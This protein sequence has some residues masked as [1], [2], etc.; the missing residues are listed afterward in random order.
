MENK[1]KD[2]RIKR[3]MLIILCSIKVLYIYLNV[4][5]LPEYWSL[6]P[7]DRNINLSFVIIEF[8]FF[9][10]GLRIFLSFY[11][12]GNPISFLSTILICLYFIPN[13]SCMTLSGYDFVYYLLV[14]SFCFILFF[15]LGLLSKHIEKKKY[16]SNSLFENSATLRNTFR[17]ITILTCFLTIGYVYLI[18]G[19]INISKIVQ[20]DTYDVRAQ[21]ADFYMKNTD[22]L[23]AY[24]MLIWTAFYTIV[25]ILGLYL[26]LVYKHY[27]DVIFI[28]F[29]YLALYTLSMEKSLLMKPII[30]IFVSIIA[31]KR[32]LIYS[33]ETFTL[34]YVGL[35]IISWVEYLFREE[36]VIYTVLI[37]RVAYMPAYLTHVFYDFFDTHEKYWFTR[38][39]FQLE[40]LVRTVYPGHYTSTIVQ[41]ISEEIYD[42]GI[43]SPNNG[44]FAEAYAQAGV[45]GIFI[46][47]PLICIAFKY[48]YKCTKNFGVGASMVVLAQFALSLISVQLLSPRNVVQI[49][50]FIILTM[51]LN[52]FMS[53]RLRAKV[54]NRH[55]RL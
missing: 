33:N 16:I 12:Q 50:I 41:T 40:K 31:R 32:K 8:V 18:G 5:M 49:L 29:T 55:S 52:A 34:G 42:G 11:K 15:L 38:D 45:W 25:L 1:I 17:F 37:R 2:R 24:I 6:F 46:I 44:M 21:L 47:P 28:L 4:L 48:L 20:E 27:L 23:L 13:N 36:S 22:G 53:R 7:F 39:F 35:M 26:A 54:F 10:I 9:F 30:A 43:P 19:G 51:L 3:N 14:N